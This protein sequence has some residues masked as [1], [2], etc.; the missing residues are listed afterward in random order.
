MRCIASD[1]RKLPR[2]VSRPLWAERFF[3]L[4][5]LVR[6]SPNSLLNGMARRLDCRIKFFHRA[7]IKSVI[8]NGY[9]L[10]FKKIL[11]LP[12]KVCKVSIISNL[13]TLGDIPGEIIV[14]R[15]YLIARR[16]LF[17]TSANFYKIDQTIKGLRS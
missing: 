4:L 5:I 8:F 2:T 6:Q 11:I 1:L 3:S 16:S 12:D 9:L 7:I 15:P 14:S 17:Q 10:I 13:C